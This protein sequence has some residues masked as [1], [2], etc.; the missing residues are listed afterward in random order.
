MENTSENTTQRVER[1]WIKVSLEVEQA[2]HLT[3]NLYNEDNYRVRQEFFK[4]GNW[5]RYGELF[6]E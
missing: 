2:C 1:T 4:T 5:L 3:N 6:Y